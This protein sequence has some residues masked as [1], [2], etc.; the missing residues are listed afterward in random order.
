MTNANVIGRYQQLRADLEAAYAEPVWDSL[1]I[2]QL[3]EDIAA[4]ERALCQGLSG[5]RWWGRGP[6]G[7]VEPDPA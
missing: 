4:A 7:L 5:V 1:R 6:L 3:A 2:D